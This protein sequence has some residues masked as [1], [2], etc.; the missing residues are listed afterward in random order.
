MT[1]N[2]T[3][4]KSFQK[5]PINDKICMLRF[6][7]QTKINY[8]QNAHS[9]KYICIKHYWRH[10]FENK[11]LLW[12][13]WHFGAIF[14]IVLGQVENAIE[15]IAPGMLVV[16]FTLTHEYT[17]RKQTNFQFK[18]FQNGSNPKRFFSSIEFLKIDSKLSVTLFD[19]K[20]NV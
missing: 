16:Y 3:K 13:G 12:F 5:K 8:N 1:K 19:F 6:K 10:F 18:S 7:Y 11:K 4:K 14:S 15:Q 20:K 2:Q 17:N 9:R